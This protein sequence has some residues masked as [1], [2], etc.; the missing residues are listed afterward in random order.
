MEAAPE[1]KPESSDGRAVVDTK[2]L[3]DDSALFPSG[4]YSRQ[5][6]LVRAECI[7][8]RCANELEL[9]LGTPYLDV[10]WIAELETISTGAGQAPSQVRNHSLD[11]LAIA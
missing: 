2:R 3:A 7:G 5:S 1:R 9:F 4:A 6:C 11:D 8:K 10:F